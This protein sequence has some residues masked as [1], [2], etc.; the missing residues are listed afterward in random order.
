VIDALQTPEQKAIFDELTGLMS[1]LEGHAD[2]V[3]DDVG[4]AV[5]PSVEIIRERFSARRE[6]VGAVDQIARRALGLDAKMRQYTDG[7]S[8]VRRVVDRVGMPGFNT[9]WTSPQHL[10]SR[11]EIHDPDGWMARVGLIA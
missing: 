8:F 4:P 2:V 7:A 9:V 6:Q 1:L 5:V 11:S 10:P 3:M